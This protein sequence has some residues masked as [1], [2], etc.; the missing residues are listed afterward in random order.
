MSTQLTSTDASSVVDSTAWHC[1][2][3]EHGDERHGTVG[4]R[5]CAATQ[6]QAL[7]RNCICRPV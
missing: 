5:F 1:E 4:R 7:H 2:M 3:C 6:S